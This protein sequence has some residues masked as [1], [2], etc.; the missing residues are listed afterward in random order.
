MHGCPA[1]DSRAF[2]SDPVMPQADR[3]ASCCLLLCARSVLAT[4]ALACKVAMQA[5]STR[6]LE[7]ASYMA[8]LI[9]LRERYYRRRKKERKLG[10]N[11]IL[12]R[13]APR[14]CKAA[15]LASYGVERT[16]SWRTSVGV[17][18]K[19]EH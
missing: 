4:L 10:G 18:P 19:S 8:A 3:I 2:I 7:A 15:K 5:R 6:L 11:L 16:R 14:P 9:E 17:P 13:V 1:D 12:C